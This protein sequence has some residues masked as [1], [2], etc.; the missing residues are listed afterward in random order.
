MSYF[1][2]RRTSEIGIRMALGATRASVV[3]MVLRGALWQILIGLGLGIPAALI[4]GHLM[5]SQLYEVSGT[6]PLALAGATLVLGLCAA[7]AGFIPAR[8][9]AS[10]EPMQALRTE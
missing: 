10:I 6:D 2:A 9:A 8:R 5:A 3:G 4:A 7:V 1:V